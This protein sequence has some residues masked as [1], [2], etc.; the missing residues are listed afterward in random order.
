MPQEKELQGERVV[1]TAFIYL[2]VS[3]QL[4]QKEVILK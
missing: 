4:L 3:D 2:W 1:L